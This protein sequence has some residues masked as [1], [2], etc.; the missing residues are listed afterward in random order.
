MVH[1]L[2]HLASFAKNVVVSFVK[3]ELADLAIEELEHIS[4]Y[5]Y[6]DMYQKL[7]ALKILLEGL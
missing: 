2:S 3:N 4:R 1:I 5:A 7:L 6:Q